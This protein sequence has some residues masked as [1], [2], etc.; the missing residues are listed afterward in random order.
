MNAAWYEKQGPAR[1]VLVVGEMP[2]P[3]HGPGEV[4]ILILSTQRPRVAQRGGQAVT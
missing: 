4:R 2:G 1:D 3:E